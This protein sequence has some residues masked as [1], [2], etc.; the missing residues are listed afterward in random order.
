MKHSLDHSTATEA[1]GIIWE[2]CSRCEAWVSQHEHGLHCEAAAAPRLDLEDAYKSLFGQNQQLADEIQWLRTVLPLKL[3]R[4]DEGLRR[5]LE[6]IR[7]KAGWS[8]ALLVG[9]I[10]ACTVVLLLRGS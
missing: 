9:W 3:E 6:Q 5:E 8:F 4:L 2:L 1:N 10:T 7:S